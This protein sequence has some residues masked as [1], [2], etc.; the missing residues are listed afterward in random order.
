M[1]NNN[2]ASG[3]FSLVPIGLVGHDVVEVITSHKSI[4]IEVSFVENMV[5]FVVTEVFTEFLANLLQLVDG[6]LSLNRYIS[7]DRFTSNEPQILS[8]SARLSFSP[9][10]AV[11]SLKNSGNSIPPD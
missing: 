3:S 9:S 2:G 8:I 7:T 6:N 1:K 11:A 10:L 4:F 5:P